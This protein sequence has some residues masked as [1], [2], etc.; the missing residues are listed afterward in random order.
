MHT[1]TRCVLA[2]VVCVSAL[3]ITA[4]DAARKPVPS[5]LWYRISAEIQG[6][7]LFTPTN[8]DLH[9]KITL[10]NKWRIESKTAVIVY[11]QCAIRGGT[12]SPKDLALIAG[13]GANESCASLIQKLPKLGFTP[14]EVQ[15]WR[16]AMV[17]DIRFNANGRVLFLDYFDETIV[18]VARV[19]VGTPPVSVKCPD[20]YTTIVLTK[21]ALST[22]SLRTDS[23][24]ER[25]V[26]VS[27]GRKGQV[28]YGVFRQ[29]A[30]ECTYQ[31]RVLKKGD[32]LTIEGPPNPSGFPPAL[33]ALSVDHLRGKYYR[34]NS[35]YG[36][37]FGGPLTLDVIRLR[38]VGAKFGTSFTVSGRQT[39]VG[40]A[41]NS[42][43][44]EKQVTYHL[45]FLL[46]PKN[47]LDAK[48]C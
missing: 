42:G 34:N 38:N 25:G 20:T 10:R 19:L 35:T 1:L 21:T 45:R 36:F 12:V 23:A 31:G 18:P 40:T 8:K 44:E 22:G 46:C 3:A 41:L 48:N 9:G 11:L 33:N 29:P 27:A 32:A 24:V 7:Y 14:A 26:G 6:K 43:K 28:E 5:R 17:D 15:R 13:L 2:L 39:R 30:Y 47:G 37:T 16:K 4:A